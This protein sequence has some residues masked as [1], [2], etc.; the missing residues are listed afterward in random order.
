MFG[1]WT[2]YKKY[3]NNNGVT[4]D[5]LTFDYD[6]LLPKFGLLKVEFH[7]F[8][9]FLLSFVPLIFLLKKEKPDYLILHL[10]TSLPLTLI[11][12]F[13]FETKFILRISGYPK[14]NY[15]RKMLWKFSGKKL[16]TITCP[17]LELKKDLIESDIF[18]SKK[19]KIL[20]DAI[21]NINDFL[22]KVRNE[23]K[24]K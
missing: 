23:K 7:I 19:Y 10:I 1:E 13:N 16:N 15:L 11:N 8:I 20:P 14:L 18:N 24:T 2:A 5:D 17:S 3:L 6:S 9:I 4:V 12:I 22:N 21:I